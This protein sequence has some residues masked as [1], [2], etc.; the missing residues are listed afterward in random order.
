MGSL[1]LQP[2]SAQ[3]EILGRR[4]ALIKFSWETP[5]G[6]SVHMGAA[7]LGQSGRSIAL[8]EPSAAR[9]WM[10]ISLREAEIASISS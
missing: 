9:G 8:S 1:T 7:A 10:N 2:F 5:R 6:V 3:Q 4:S